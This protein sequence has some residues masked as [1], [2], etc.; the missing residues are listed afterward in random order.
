MAV[1]KGATTKDCPASRPPDHRTDIDLVH[2]TVRVRASAAAITGA[3][4]IVGGSKS[5]A[6]FR[7]V[8]LPRVAVDALENHLATFGQPKPHGVVSTGDRGGPLNRGELSA[9]WRKA[10]DAVPTAPT[11]LHAHDL[12][13]SAATMMARLPGVTTKEIMGRLGHASPRAAADLPA[14]DGRAGPADCRL[15]RRQSSAAAQSAETSRVSVTPLRR[16]LT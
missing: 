4:R 11:G 9:A 14:W 1:T 2:R 16:G 8:A 10:V 3:G 5:E 15:P 12:R 6:G 7:T 13:H